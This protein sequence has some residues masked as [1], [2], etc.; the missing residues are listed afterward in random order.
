MIVRNILEVKIMADYRKWLNSLPLIVK[1]ILALPLLDGIFYGIYRICS[2]KTVNVVLGIVW[3][4][5]GAT[6]GWI[7]DIVFLLLEKPVFE[8]NS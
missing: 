8:L 6:I 3:I 4:F 1:I 2:G 5:V 7:L